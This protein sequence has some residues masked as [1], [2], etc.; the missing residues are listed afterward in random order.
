MY[1]FNP[2]TPNVKSKNW[3]LNFGNLNLFLFADVRREKESR[4]T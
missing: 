2:K 1:W 3:R 4:K